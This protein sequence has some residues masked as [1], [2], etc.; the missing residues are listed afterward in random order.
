MVAF[1]TDQPDTTRQT[2]TPDLNEAGLHPSEN[3]IE[4]LVHLIRHYLEIGFI[5]DGFKHRFAQGVTQATAGEEVNA[6]GEPSDV[7][8]LLTEDIQVT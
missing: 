1:R 2:T 3:R 6:F 7:G 4:V 8:L 5:Q